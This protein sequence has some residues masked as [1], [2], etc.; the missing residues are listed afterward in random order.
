MAFR[1]L[2]VKSRRAASS[3]HEVENATVVSAEPHFKS[4]RELFNQMAVAQEMERQQVH[5]LVT[6]PLFNRFPRH[7][8]PCHLLTS[9]DSS[10]QWV[11]VSHPSPPVDAYSAS[12][13]DLSAG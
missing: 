3:A 4:T 9:M 2:I 7:V 13:A 1:A 5:S 10:I 12:S 8:T 11:F 6:E